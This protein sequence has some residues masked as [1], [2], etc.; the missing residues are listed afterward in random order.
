MS[1]AINQ[2]CPTAGMFGVILQFDDYAFIEFTY[3]VILIF[4][5]QDPWNKHWTEPKATCRPY[6]ILTIWTAW[7]TSWYLACWPDAAWNQ[8]QGESTY[9]ITNRPVVQLARIYE[10][11]SLGHGRNIYFKAKPIDLLVI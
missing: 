7:V 4:F 8:F 1:L 6:K 2:T 5:V 11:I 10:H 3:K 9:C